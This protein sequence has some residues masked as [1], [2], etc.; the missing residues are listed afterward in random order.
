MNNILPASFYLAGKPTWWGSLPFPA[1]GPDVKG[2][3]GPGSH[4]Y[5]N[6]AQNCYLKVLGGTDGGLGG[7]LPF[8]AGNCYVTDKIVSSPVRLPALNQSP[9]EPVSLT[10]R[11]K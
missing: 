7:P 9:L 8:N 6:P 10:L 11:W 5:G 1:I 4:S 2:G 3:T